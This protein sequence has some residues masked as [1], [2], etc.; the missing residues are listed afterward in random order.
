MDLPQRLAISAVSQKLF[1][2]WSTIRRCVAARER[3]RILEWGYRECLEGL[4]AA[5]AGLRPKAET[6]SLRQMS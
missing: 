3:Q 6:R 4:R 2:G 5:L 1:L